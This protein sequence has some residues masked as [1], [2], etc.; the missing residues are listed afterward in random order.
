M[1]AEAHNYM[2]NFNETL[3]AN[4]WVLN[5][6]RQILKKFIGNFNTF[7]MTLMFKEC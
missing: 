1:P 6:S 4:N 3:I 7:F 2:S 5:K